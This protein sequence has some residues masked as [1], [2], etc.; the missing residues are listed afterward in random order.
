MG[1]SQSQVIVEVVAPVALVPGI[2]LP[3]LITGRYGR[4]RRTV[5]IWF[6]SP[7]PHTST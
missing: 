7:L 3:P 4:H 1:Q 2:A 5:V 6:W